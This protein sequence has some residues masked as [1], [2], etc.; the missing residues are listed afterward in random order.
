MKMAFF[1]LFL[2]ILGEPHVITGHVFALPEEYAESVVSLLAFGLAYGVYVLHRRDVK[3]K[4]EHVRQIEHEGRITQEKLIDA[5]EY[6]GVVNRRLPLLKKLTSDLLATEKGSEKARKDMFQRL[7]AVAV[8]SVAKAEWGM[9][10]FVESAH[11]Q[12]VKEF[13]YTSRHFLLLK[14]SVSNRELIQTREQ[15]KN[16][17]E[18]GEL[19][20]IPTTD[21]EMPVQGYLVFPK[22]MNSDLG[23]EV[24]VFQAIVDQAQLLYKYLYS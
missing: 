5:F 6:I 11:E 9:F 3:R 20:V 23:D 4:E 18:I 12:T 7:L 13:V 24:S 19:C 21:Q 16:V 2:V 8:T 22:T 10:R 15:K 14:T 17:R 1:I